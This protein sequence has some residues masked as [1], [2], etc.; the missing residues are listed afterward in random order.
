[1]RRPTNWTAVL[2]LTAAAGLAS[3][4][5]AD[6]TMVQNVTGK[7]IVDAS[8]E[9]TTR[10]K[11]NKMRIDTAR[12]NE[13]STVI[14]DIDGQQMIIIDQKK[15]EATVMPVAQLQEALGKAGGS[16]A[17]MTVKSKVTPTGEKK[18]VAGY[19]CAVHDISV[20]VPFSMTKDEKDS[21]TM[22]MSGPACLS[23]DAPGFADFSRLAAAA[24]E[25]GFVFSDPRTVKGPGASLAKGMAELNKTMSEAGIPLE[26]TTNL[27]LEGSGPAASLMGRFMKG[28]TTSTLVKI[29]EGDIPADVFVVPA[30]FKVKTQ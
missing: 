21:M 16:G 2:C 9:T 28:T 18:Q 25:K 14:L 15:K 12:G 19:N 4:A 3:P 30:G 11:G 10:I 29:T 20:A 22:V 23:K 17:H 24:A 13:V 1:M 5:H 26:Q 27:S 6:V 7:I 8:G